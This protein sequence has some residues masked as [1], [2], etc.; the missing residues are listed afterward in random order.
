[1][2]VSFHVIQF[3]SIFFSSLDSNTLELFGNWPNNITG[4][5]TSIYVSVISADQNKKQTKPLVVKKVWC[6]KIWWNVYDG[7]VANTQNRSQIKG[8]QIQEEATEHDY[9]SLQMA[10]IRAGLQKVFPFSLEY[11]QPL[12]RALFK[13][14][15]WHFR[16]FRHS[17]SLDIWF[18]SGFNAIKRAECHDSLL[19]AACFTLS[20]ATQQL[21]WRRFTEMCLLISSTED[22]TAYFKSYLIMLQNP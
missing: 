3:L 22:I 21:L 17:L 14:G 2:F 9:C 4:I 6:S 13:D 10:S 19:C 8:W 16:K 15:Y 12:L 7:H 1:M 5:Y 18:Q 20:S 11:V